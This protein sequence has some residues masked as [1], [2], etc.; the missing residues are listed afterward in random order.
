MLTLP[1]ATATMSLVHLPTEI[2]LMIESHLGTKKDLNAPIRISPRF[3]LMFEDKLYKFNTAQRHEYVISWTID[4]DLD[5]T[6]RKCL[7]AGA[8]ITLRDPFKSHLRTSNAHE[9]ME[10]IPR[11]PRAQ[12][13]TLAARMGSMVC[14]RLLLEQS[15]NANLLHEHYESPIRLAAENGHVKVVKYLLNKHPNAFTGT[16]KLREALLGAAGQG[17]LNVKEAAQIILYGGLWNHE[18]DVVIYALRKGADVNDESL[19]PTFRFSP[20]IRANERPDRPRPKLVQAHKTRENV[21]GIETFDWSVE[22][23]NTMYAALLRGDENLLEL[24]FDHGCDLVRLG[25]EALGYAILWR[26]RG[27]IIRLMEMG[28]TF[29]QGPWYGS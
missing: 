14:V 12:P 9:I 28:V 18:E 13:L 25:P 2:I 29:T 22:I 23:P 15:V 21:H 19:S 8:M 1:L 24:I 20:D 4:R 27:L 16:F 7:R 6:I 17:Y 11:H 3:T 10:I 5:G 26:G